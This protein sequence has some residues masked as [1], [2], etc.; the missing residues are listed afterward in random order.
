MPVQSSMRSGTSLR[1]RLMCLLVPLLTPRLT[2]PNELEPAI[3]ADRAR[4]PA[5]PPH[6]IAKRLEVRE[7]LLG[8]RRA[9]QAIRK[10]MKSSKL[11]IFYL[12][13]GA[14]V[15]DLL[16][17]QWTIID[18]LLCRVGGEVVVP[19]YPLAPEHDWL[20]G[21][22][23]IDAAYSELLSNCEAKDIVVVSDSA[24]GGLS[25]ALVQRLRDAGGMLPAAVVLLSPWL[26][27]SVSGTDQPKIEQNDPA[28]TIE[29]LRRAGKL[30]TRDLPPDD[31]RVS[32]LFG[33]QRGLP[34]TIVFSGTRD[35]LDSDA[36]RLAQ[37]NPGISLRR[38]PGMIHVWLAAPLPEA[39]RA[40]DEAAEFIRR[41]VDSALN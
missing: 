29:F 34:P 10:G 11:R 9:F 20:E 27:M 3:A 38:Y 13:G 6:R 25:L 18:K 14:Y 35:I 36:Q 7:T 31:P 21:H 15:L 1:A 22:D 40:L 28:L 23:A 32:P 39:K 30:W 33:D 12:H 2:G 26:D 4:G 17:V 5:L 19:I 16:P 8:G 41:N 24:G 37:A